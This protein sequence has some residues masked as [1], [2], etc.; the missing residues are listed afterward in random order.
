[1][2]PNQRN[3]S[4]LLYLIKLI[5]TK[6]VT[7]PLL[8][9]TKIGKVFTKITQLTNVEDKEVLKQAGIVLDAWKEMNRQSKE[10]DS[11][12]KKQPES[13]GCDSPTKEASEPNC[14]DDLNQA[15]S[16]VEDKPFEIKEAVLANAK[17]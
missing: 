10:G 13:N 14:H 9:A 15:L 16:L 6:N 8:A 3:E 2:E 17:K 12:E 1:M 4:K 11:K 7:L 5:K